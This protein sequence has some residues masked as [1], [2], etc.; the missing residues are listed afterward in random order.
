MGGGQTEWTGS[1]ERSVASYEPFSAVVLGVFAV[2]GTVVVDGVDPPVLKLL[3][4]LAVPVDVCETFAATVGLSYRFYLD[5]E[6]VVSHDGL[7]DLVGG[8]VFR[9]SSVM[10]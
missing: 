3:S 4:K 2:F 8:W 9:C 1:F 6:V 5:A 7:L 10:K